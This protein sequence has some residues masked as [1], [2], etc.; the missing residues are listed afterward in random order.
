V[1]VL[2]APPAGAVV[3]I[4]GVYDDMPEDLYHSDPVPG[5]SLSSSGARKLLP[6][7]CPAKFRYEMDHPAPATDAMEKGTAAHKAVLG[8]GAPLVVVDAENWR[9]TA[10]K[11]ARDQARAAG[12][13]PLLPAD[14][15]QVQEMA[16]AIRAHPVAGV[17]F[18]PARGGSPEQSLFWEDAATGVW[19]R[20]RLDW[21]PAAGAGRLIIPDYKTTSA[22]NLDAIRRH[23]G[24][25]GYHCQDAWYCDAVRA[26]GLDGDPAFVFVF[27]ETTPPYLVTVIELDPEARRA[28]YEANRVALE[29]YRDCKQAGRWPGYSDVIELVSLPPWA[30]RRYLEGDY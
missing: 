14:F 4:P 28:G 5:G 27:Q 12:A 1:T 29:I 17:L 10:A 19:R 11:A 23:A 15:T 2:D 24:G 16:L 26:V 7:S 25:F 13:V 20:A 30:R 22:A 3:E 6:P 9:T 21:L 18:D 8:V